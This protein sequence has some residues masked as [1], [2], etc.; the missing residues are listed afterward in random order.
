MSSPGAQFEKTVLL[1]RHG[2]SVDNGMPVHQAADADLSPLGREQAALVAERLRDADIEALVSSTLPR[3]RQTAEFIA[4]ATGK[5][6]EF[7]GLFVERI[8]PLEIHGKSTSDAAANET[9]QRWIESMETPG[10]PVLEGAENYDTILARVDDGLAYLAGRPEKRLAV[11]THGYF[12]RTLLAQVIM[13]DHLTP[14]TMLAI[15]GETL[16]NPAN[17]S[18]TELQLRQA[19]TGELVWALGAYNDCTHLPLDNR[20]SL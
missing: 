1:V 9:Y 2:Q 15:R 12:T 7:S 17:A 18:L 10:T 8:K 11:V 13:G 6:P 19:A 14:S 3:A 16:V 20:T 5:A 4:E